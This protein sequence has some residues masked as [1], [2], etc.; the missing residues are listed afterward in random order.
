[1]TKYNLCIL[2]PTVSSVR[3]RNT[4]NQ[5]KQFLIT[6]KYQIGIHIYSQ[7][8]EVKLEEEYDITTISSDTNVGTMNANSVVRTTAPDAEY[9]MYIDDDFIFHPGFESD[10]TDVLSRL[11]A[12]KIKATSLI[13]SV[14]G[15][16]S[17]KFDTTKTFFREAR[18]NEIPFL[19]KESGIILHNSVFT[20]EHILTAYGE[21]NAKLTHAYLDG[22]D[23]YLA[24]VKITHMNN[25]N[26]DDSWNTLSSEIFED[27]NKNLRRNFYGKQFFMKYGYMDSNQRLTPVAIEIHKYNKMRLE[28]KNGRT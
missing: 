17:Y 20:K 8:F 14:T 25:Q 22:H 27:D 9:Y 19:R 7:G 1:M 13:S 12:F 15:G 4:L 24:F 11:D 5:L 26:E 18:I 28:I 3:C 2:L 21:D 6:N 23:V 16:K 10:L